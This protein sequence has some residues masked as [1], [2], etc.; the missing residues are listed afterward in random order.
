MKNDLLGK[1]DAEIL[2]M[3]QILKAILI[4]ST[5]AM[6]ILLGLVVYLLFVKDKPIFSITL[7]GLVLPYIFLVSI[8]QKY[9]GEKKRRNL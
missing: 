9:D 6:L 3:Y 1:S 4:I 7:G 5:I 8:Y 2:K